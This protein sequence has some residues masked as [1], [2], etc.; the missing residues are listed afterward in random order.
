MAD[1]NRPN[2]Y[3]SNDPYRRAPEPAREPAGTDPLAELA[4]LIGQNDPMADFGRREP[5]PQAYVPRERAPHW[6]PQTTPKHDVPEQFAGEFRDDD[7]GFYQQQPAAE[8]Y[9]SPLAALAARAEARR[10]EPQPMSAPRYEP[11]AP[12]FAAYADDRIPAMAQAQGYEQDRQPEGDEAYYQ[13]E[14]AYGPN[15]EQIYDDA[16]R[17]RRRGGLATALALI[18]C[19][20]LGTAGAYAYRSYS[21]P[22]GERSPPPTITAEATPIKTVTAPAADPQAAKAISERF[23]NAANPDNLVS[24]QE[25]PVVLREPSAPASPPRVVLPSPVSPGG[26]N[27]PSSAA[28]QQPPGTTPEAAPKRV[29]TV[30]IRPDANDNSGRPVAGNAAGAPQAAPTPPAPRAAAQPRTPAQGGGP[31]SL[32]PQGQPVQSAQPAA[33]VAA[34]SP[35]SYVVQLSSQKSESE[36]QSSFRALQEKFPNELGGRQLIIRRADLGAK[37]VVYRANV[38]PFATAS[39]AQQFCASYKAAGGQCIVPSN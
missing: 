9:E 20:L 22:S 36:A 21:A 13:D 27:P 26:A 2:P 17:A 18:G 37:G 15:D 39:E 28:S 35:G 6:P 3:R 33:R 32:S 12:Q 1:D 25:E 19:A 38:G 29:R 8:P 34:T 7:R 14:A 10:A 5:Q 24:R 30:T 11:E 4:R 31:L 16:P 23:A